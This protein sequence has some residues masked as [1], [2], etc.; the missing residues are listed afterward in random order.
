[1]K[2]FNA[3]Q[4]LSEWIVE[5]QASFKG[6]FKI[7]KSKPKS[8]KPRDIRDEPI[9]MKVLNDRVAREEE[10]IHVPT[11]ARLKKSQH[12]FKAY[13]C[14]NPA[15]I[16]DT[17]SLIKQYCPDQDPQHIATDEQIRKYQ[18]LQKEE[19]QR[20][21][22]YHCTIIETRMH[23]FCGFIDHMAIDPGRTLF[24]V[25]ITVTP[26]E[27]EQMALTRQYRSP[28]GKLYPLTLNT[29]NIINLLKSRT[30]IL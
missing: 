15:K 18:L 23:L 4:T 21:K 20:T 7:P 24:E 29:D 14:N 22:G 13:E 12:Y 9:D 16:H 8:R 11:N 30:S 3:N 2:T 19:L 5:T 25:P 26:S 10:K 17:S 27:C 6:F 28:N 1:M